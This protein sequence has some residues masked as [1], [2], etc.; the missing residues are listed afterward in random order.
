[1]TY[2]AFMRRFC[3]GWD[4]TSKPTRMFHTKGVIENADYW[5]A[6]KQKGDIQVNEKALREPGAM[7]EV[8][9]D[10]ARTTDNMA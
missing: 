5:D 2:N 1:M 6:M 4:G 10:A 3:K 7:L 8:F 9:C